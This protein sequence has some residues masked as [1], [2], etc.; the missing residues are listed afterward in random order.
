[1]LLAWK[2]WESEESVKEYV[3]G[4]IK[5]Q[6]G[7]LALLKGFEWESFSITIGDRVAKRNKKMNKES[8][9]IFID[10]AELDKRVQEVSKA[11]LSEEN[12]AIIKLYLNPPRD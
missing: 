2:E 1:M 9:A 4:V 11:K 12:K 8:L 10:I 3:A 7:L 6:A 5:T